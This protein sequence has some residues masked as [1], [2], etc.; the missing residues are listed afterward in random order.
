MFR[1]LTYAFL[2][3]LS[4]AV[5][6][7]SP[8]FAKQN[9]SPKFDG[10][11]AGTSQVAPQLSGSS[12]PA[13]GDAKVKIRKGII[14]S[15]DAKAGGRFGGIVVASGFVTGKYRMKGLKAEAQGLIDRK[16][17]ELGLRSADAKCFWLM[18]LTRQ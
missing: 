7:G 3:A 6:S 2:I 15:E 12:C 14:A 10:T 1:P 9:V 18:H 17:M 16:S 13:L 5:S 11:Y 4:A 8:A